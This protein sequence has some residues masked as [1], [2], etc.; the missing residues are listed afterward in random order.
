MAR[1]AAAA[2]PTKIQDDQAACTYKGLLRESVRLHPEL[3]PSFSAMAGASSKGDLIDPARL[4]FVRRVGSGAFAKVDICELSTPGKQ[5]KS[6]VAVKRLIP[7]VHRLSAVDL[8]VEARLLRSITHPYITAFIGVGVDGKGAGFLVEE[9]VGGGTLNRMVTRQ[10]QKPHKCIF[11]HVEAAAWVEQVA[12]A[13]AYLHDANPVIIHRDLK[14]ANI[15]LR[16]VPEAGGSLTCAVCDF[17]LSSSFIN[18]SVR[19]GRAQLNRSLGPEGEP[20]GVV[21]NGS[22]A[23]RKRAAAAAGGEGGS[24]SR[25]GAPPTTG[26]P[27]ERRLSAVREQF[28]R[29]SRGE[30]MD[31]STVAGRSAAL[32]AALQAWPE[33]RGDGGSGSRGAAGTGRRGSPGGGA[34]AA[35]AGGGGG[36]GRGARPRPVTSK[37]AADL[38]GRT[39]SFMYMA[40]EVTRSKPYSEKADVFSFGVVLY[41]LFA[42][43]TFAAVLLLLSRGDP[44]DCEI[45]AEKVARGYR[46]PI[47]SRWPEP[48]RELVASCWA[49]E[50]EDRP[51]MDDVARMIVSWRGGRRGGRERKKN[52]AG[53]GSLLSPLLTPFFFC[54]LTLHRSLHSC[55]LTSGM[56]AALSSGTWP[57]SRRS[58]TRAAG[59]A[60]G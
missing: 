47:P 52:G 21:L 27:M 13:L 5:G 43:Q 55:R 46:V 30:L 36:G 51:S 31:D 42:R 54:T 56:R 14:L 40:P 44:V 48:V 35:T 26:A 37:A 15:L 8:A 9:Y 12:L 25:A 22:F 53:N 24:D 1:A 45:Y 38:T 19:L 60:A 2:D 16:E 17:G 41:Q 57:G 18:P 33:P 39:G 4:R 34:T 7:G 29:V 58:R 11:T 23:D 3:A 6:M 10:M 28:A 20:P 49:Q 50:P 59:R 32:D